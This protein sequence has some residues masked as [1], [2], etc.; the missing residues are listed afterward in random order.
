MLTI[1]MITVDK[2]MVRI[3]CIF[4]N[5]IQFYVRN[6]SYLMKE[7]DEIDFWKYISWDGFHSTVEVEKLSF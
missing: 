1:F 3:P 7:P 2:K 5:M 4:N 6:T